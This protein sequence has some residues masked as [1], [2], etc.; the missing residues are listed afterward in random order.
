MIIMLLSVY[1]PQSACRLNKN[2]ILD[3]FAFISSLR[4][5]QFLCHSSLVPRIVSECLFQSSSQKTTLVLGVVFE[6]EF[7]FIPI[8]F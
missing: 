4:Y 3:I 2:G 7:D 1:N 8:K 5:R 6:G